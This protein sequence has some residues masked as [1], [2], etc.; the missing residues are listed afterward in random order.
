MDNQKTLN[1]SLISAVGR[2]E[3]AVSGEEMV[4]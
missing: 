3:A 1:E 2:W 4:Q